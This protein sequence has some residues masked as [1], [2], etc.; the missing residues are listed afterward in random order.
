MLDPAGQPYRERVGV[1]AEHGF[2]HVAAHVI[3]VLVVMAA[4]VIDVEGA[5]E[6][7]LGEIVLLAR[8]VQDERLVAELETGEIV[9]RDFRGP[10][11]HIALVRDLG[12]AVQIVVDVDVG[13]LL[14]RPSPTMPLAA[15]STA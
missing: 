10:R 1:P 2:Q 11:R 3:V 9:E 12:D 6:I 14:A 15:I 13:V 8:H 7:H 4:R 5:M